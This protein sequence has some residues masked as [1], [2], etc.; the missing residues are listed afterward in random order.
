MLLYFYLVA[1]LKILII[2]QKKSKVLS[3]LLESKE[4]VGIIEPREDKH[5]SSIVEKAIFK[6]I[7]S[8]AKNIT[9]LIY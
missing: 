6:N 7:K 5:L 3:T 1:N 9:F 2:T 4:V 8:V